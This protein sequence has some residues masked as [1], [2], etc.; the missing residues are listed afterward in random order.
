[1]SIKCSH[2]NKIIKENDT[3][4]RCCDAFVCSYNCAISRFNY[5]NS[6]DPN[7]YYAYSWQNKNLKKNLFGSSNIVP[8]KKIIKKIII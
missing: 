4:N 7:L 2:C 5:I 8:K 3:Y 6:V 1:M